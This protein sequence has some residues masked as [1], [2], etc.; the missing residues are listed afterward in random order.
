MAAVNQQYD[1]VVKEEESYK[2]KNLELEG[3]EQK[4]IA[5]AIGRGRVSKQSVKAL[6]NGLAHNCGLS[7][8]GWV[9]VSA[10]RSIEKTSPDHPKFC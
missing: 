1:K 8:S 3:R 9:V 6:Q 2:E 5:I 7:S 10:Q 4:L